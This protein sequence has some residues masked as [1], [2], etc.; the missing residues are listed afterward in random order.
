[1]TK[2]KAALLIRDCLVAMQAAGEIQEGDRSY[3]LL[4]RLSFDLEN[5]TW[6]EISNEFA[7]LALDCIRWGGMIAVVGRCEGEN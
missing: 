4:C 1:M 5:C 7:A 2:R 3:E 6:E